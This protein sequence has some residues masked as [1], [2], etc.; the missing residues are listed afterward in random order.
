MSPNEFGFVINLLGEKN[1]EKGHSVQE[2]NFRSI[3]FGTYATF[4]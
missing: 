3:K 2:S 4:G 1:P